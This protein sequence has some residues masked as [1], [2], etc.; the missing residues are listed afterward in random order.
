MDELIAQYNRL[1]YFMVNK[2]KWILDRSGVYDEDDLYQI[3][4][5]ALIRANE[6]YNED[7][8]AFSTWACLMIKQDFLRLLQG[9]KLAYLDEPINE[10]G[11]TLQ[12]LLPDDESASPEENTE[13]AEECQAVHDAVNRLNSQDKRT[14]I[15]EGFFK[16]KTA[17]QIAEETGKSAQ[18]VTRARTRAL[19]DL[20]KDWRLCQV[21][22]NT[23]RISAKRQ[24]SLWTSEVE[25]NVLKREE[26]YDKFFGEGSYAQA[27]KI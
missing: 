1:I 14:A 4:V 12:E 9:P 6:S 20:S 26:A 18:A 10:N 5:L 27:S 8:G 16:G 7:C 22:G 3:G 15:E 17:Q 11:T 2:Y 23:Y 19:Y 13:R 24:N 21:V 25:Y